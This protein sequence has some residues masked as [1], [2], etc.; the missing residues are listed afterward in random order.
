LAFSASI[1]LKHLSADEWQP[2]RSYLPCPWPE[3]GR[4]AVADALCSGDGSP[5]QHVPQSR[6]VVAFPELGVREILFRTSLYADDMAIFILPCGQDIQLTKGILDI[7]HKSSG[8]ACN[9]NKS[10]MIPIRCSQ[11]QIAFSVQEF[12]CQ[13][14]SFPIKYLGIPLLVSKLLKSALQPLVDQVADK[15]PA[16]CGHLMH[17]S[18]RLTLIKTTLCA[19]SV[20]TS[21]SLGLPQWLYRA[22]RKV[23]TMFLWTGSD[24]VQKG[25]WLVAWQCI[26]RPLHLGSLGV[27]NLKRLGMALCLRCLG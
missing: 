22:L 21:I 11:E 5:R 15:L 13:L 7:F 27:M 19:V 1:H 4:P 3:A 2:R 24:L 10:Q 14:E 16:W 12:P 8:L 17:R 9:L 26:E 20:Y 23:V 18:G 25:K 6:C